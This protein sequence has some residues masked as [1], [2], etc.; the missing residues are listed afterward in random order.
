MK[1]EEINMNTEYD[2][3]EWAAGTTRGRQVFNFGYRLTGRELK[4]LKLL[5]TV[6]MQESR[7]LIEK[8]YLWGSSSDP[9]HEMIR[10]SITE[11]FYWKLAQETLHQY[12]MECTRPNIPKGTKK[13]AQ[14][15]DVNYVT[16]EPQ[17]NIAGAI[18]FTRGNVCVSVSSAGEKNVD[19]SEMAAVLERALSEPPAKADASR[20][21][22]HACI[23]EWV[24]VTA[25]KPV[26]LVEKLPEAV[27]RGGWL[28]IIVPDGELRRKGDALIYVSPEGGK[29]HVSAFAASGA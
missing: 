29:K 25:R 20:P 27:P 4:D 16:R 13:Y 26:V 10:V 14:L 2:K 15:G 21:K 12:L 3:D 5:K 8:V 11:R 6:L 1:N 28:K 23:P 7:D 18:M 9:K 19:V 24:D 22:V 17:T